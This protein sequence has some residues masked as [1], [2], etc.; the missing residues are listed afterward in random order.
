MTNPLCGG[1]GYADA[2][3]TS[4]LT[5][6]L[7]ALTV[8]ILATPDVAD[9]L[10]VGSERGTDASLHG[11]GTFTRA[12]E[13]AAYFRSATVTSAAE[14]A[15]DLSF[16]NLDIGTSA[17]KRK[18]WNAKKSCIFRRKSIYLF[19]CLVHVV[20]IRKNSLSLCLS[21]SPGETSIRH[22]PNKLYS[23]R[24]NKAL[25]ICSGSTKLTCVCLPTILTDTDGFKLR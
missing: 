6:F 13:C 14:V 12:A 23:K 19:C 10:H 25:L 18:C 1:R 4:G 17:T 22:L 5:A 15:A 3:S 24:S 21:V 7:I 9:R 20:M 8:E 16:G 2:T 11:G